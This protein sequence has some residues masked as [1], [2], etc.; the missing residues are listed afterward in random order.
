MSFNQKQGLYGSY[1]GTTDPETW[2][3][4]ESLVHLGNYAAVCVPQPLMTTPSTA[5]GVQKEKVPCI[6]DGVLLWSWDPH[7]HLRGAR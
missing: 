7:S 3:R 5:G 2:L 1:R 4:K 6:S